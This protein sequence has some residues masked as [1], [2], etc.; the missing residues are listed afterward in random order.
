MDMNRVIHAFQR[1]R[2]DV[3]V[4]HTAAEAAGYMDTVIDGTTVGFGDSETLRS[5]GLYDRLCSHNRVFDPKHPEAGRDFT[6]TA[7][8]CMLTDI[9]V[10]SVNGASE[11][12]IMVN[13]DGM[14]NRAGASLFGHKKVF[15]VFGI[16]KLRPTLEGAIERVRNEAAPKNAVRHGYTDT[17][18][19]GPDRR[20][21]D[22]ASPNRMCNAMVIYYK[23]MKRTE[24]EVII[25]EEN[26]GL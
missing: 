2:Y 24:A 1:N 20:C 11:T 16:N 21:H 26:L 7:R 3:H 8:E 13:M 17:G 25:I 19:V 6:E 10:T 23:K 15:F 14:G 12:G 22:C 5:L 9:F 18:C 4:F